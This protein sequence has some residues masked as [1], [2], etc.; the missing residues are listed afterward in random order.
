MKDLYKSGI[1]FKKGQ[2]TILA[3]RPAMGKS[4]FAL[5]ICLDFL[6]RGK[7]VLFLSLEC[8]SDRVL[9][10]LKSIHF[11]KHEDK[12]KDLEFHFDNL[13]IIDTVKFR[14]DF[15]TI[16]NFAELKI[17]NKIDLLII[18]YIQL[19]ESKNVFQNRYEEIDFISRLIKNFSIDNDCHSLILSQLSRKVEERQGHRPI[20]TDLRDSGT[21]EE[22]ADQVISIFRREYYDRND[23]PGLAELIVLK[24]RFGSLFSIFFN[25]NRE[26]RK[27]YEYNSSNLKDGQGR[28]WVVTED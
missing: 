11:E 2:T 27:F 22:F 6:K 13:E 12:C 21:M 14:K 25:F 28:N 20:L 5:N 4:S 7:H 10:S 26:L 3:S 8:S 24:N 18:D 1:D 17:S 15:K 23:K 19:A 16:E 9:N